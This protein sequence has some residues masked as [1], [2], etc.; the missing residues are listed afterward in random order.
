M[1]KRKRFFDFLENDFGLLKK[2]RRVRKGGPM[3]VLRKCVAQKGG[4][5]MAWRPSMVS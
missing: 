4:V 2:R 3:S 1:M 5:R